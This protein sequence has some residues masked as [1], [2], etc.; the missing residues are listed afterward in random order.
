M[1]SQLT[2]STR[3]PDAK[4][5]LVELNQMETECVMLCH[6]TLSQLSHD[7]PLIILTFLINL[8]VVSY[9]DRKGEQNEEEEEEEAV[10]VGPGGRCGHIRSVGRHRVTDVSSGKTW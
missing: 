4:Y 2:V 3:G 8:E 6:T 7:G 1:D 10:T 9:G 5:A